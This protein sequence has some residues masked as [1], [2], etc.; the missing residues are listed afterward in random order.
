MLAVV[1]CYGTLAAVALLSFVGITVDI[2]E[3]TLVKLVTVV[4]VLA[5]LGMGHSYRA[6]RHPGPLVLAVVAAA[7]LAWV[8]FG[9][10]SKAL[11]LAGFAVLLLASG[12]DFRVR[13]RACALT[14]SSCGET[15]GEWP[16]Q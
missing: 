14:Q 5:L 4:L 7:L 2:D 9:R 8:F 11:E 16:E 13:K 6:H 15:A 3:A 12:W 1:A 10:Y